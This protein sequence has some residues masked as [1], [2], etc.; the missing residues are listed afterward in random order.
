MT[1]LFQKNWIQVFQNIGTKNINM[2]VIQKVHGK[3][4]LGAEGFFKIHAVFSKYAFSTNFLKYFCIFFKLISPKKYNRMVI[5]E[6][7]YKLC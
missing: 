6:Y 1:S 2:R 7:N 4:C 5:N 3:V